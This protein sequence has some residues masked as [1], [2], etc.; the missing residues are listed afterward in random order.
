[1]MSKKKTL[2]VAV[3]GLSLWADCCLFLFIQL[4]AY[5]VANYT[6]HDGE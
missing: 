5:V 6:C 3:P 4:L 1:M 2:G